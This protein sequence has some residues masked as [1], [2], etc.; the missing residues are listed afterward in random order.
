M[1]YFDYAASTPLHPQAAKV[2]ENFSQHCYGNTTS[3]HE[4]GSEAKNIVTYCRNQFA[5]RLG[6]DVEGIYF[7]SGGTESNLLSIISLAKANQHKGK[8]IITTLGEH[9]SV[10]S[11][12][13]YLEDDGFSITKIP[14]IKEGTVDL[15]L[16]AKA[17]TDET[18]LISVQ[19]SNPEI[20]II[21]P[22]EEIALL[23]NTHGIL[24]H[25]DCVQSFGKIELENIAKC[26]DSLTLSG[27]KF[28]GPK[29]IGIAYIHP[30]HRIVPVF[31]GLIHEAGF[32]GGTLNVPAIAAMSEALS[33]LEP[34]IDRENSMQSFRD[35]FVSKLSTYPEFFSIYSATNKKNQLPH[36]VG[37]R[38]RQTEGQLMMLELNRHGYAISTGSACQVG[39]LNA[40]KI[41]IALKIEPE[42]AKEFIRISF[43]KSTTLHSVMTLADR[44]IQIQQQLQ[45]TKTSSLVSVIK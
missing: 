35:L 29:G 15:N 43:G 6:V 20:G 17:I 13:E 27:H 24:L 11:A 45:R 18:I 31:P 10:D 42:Q 39:Q 7:T 21:Q 41:M 5:S 30:R 8:H 23:A 19:H 38:T 9:P 14:F 26:V 2:Y 22:I 1:H 36:I 4:I 16:L 44:M 12:F 40:S 33:Q 37:L 28:Y 3:L 25:S 34:T 32:R